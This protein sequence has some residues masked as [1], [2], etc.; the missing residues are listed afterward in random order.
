MR[1]GKNRQR[2]VHLTT[3]MFQQCGFVCDDCRC[4]DCSIVLGVECECGDRHGTPSLNDPKIC[5][6]CWHIRQ[7][8]T[9]MDAELLAMRAREIEEQEPIYFF[10]APRKNAKNDAILDESNTPHTTAET[11]GDHDDT[12]PHMDS[13]TNSEISDSNFSDITE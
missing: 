1:C 9:T 3:S 7:R 4:A 5:V 10:Q 12:P 8:E 2:P 11:N 6:D 13:A